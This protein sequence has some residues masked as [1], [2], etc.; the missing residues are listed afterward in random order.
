MWCCVYSG[1]PTNP[2][3]PPQ[4]PQPPRFSF[5]SLG[6][7]MWLCSPR[8]RNQHVKLPLWRE[9]P[10]NTKS[11]D[12][13]RQLNIFFGVSAKIGLVVEVQG[14]KE[15]DERR[16]SFN[17]LRIRHRLLFK[18]KISQ[19]PPWGNIS[20]FWGGWFNVCIFMTSKTNH[21]HQE[22]YVYNYY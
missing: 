6:L 16:W 7:F 11:S 18:S 13:W 4:T 20:N 17:G 3:Q 1:V 12:R 21:T 2:S 22:Y 10:A 5:F 19:N 8:F 15:L 14:K 9:W